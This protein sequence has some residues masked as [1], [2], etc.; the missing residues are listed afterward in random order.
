[1]S[2]RKIDLF[3]ND[4]IRSI[5]KIERYTERKTYGEFINDELLIDGVIRNLEIIGEAAKKFQRNLGESIPS[6]FRAVFRR[7]IS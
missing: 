2:E 1:M 6:R 7:E 5:Q 3:L 4:I